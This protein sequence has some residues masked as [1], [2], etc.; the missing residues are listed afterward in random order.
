MEYIAN[1][2]KLEKLDDVLN[3]KL[4][5]FQIFFLFTPRKGLNR[6]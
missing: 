1:K 6:K 4:E 2:L 5:N 3:F